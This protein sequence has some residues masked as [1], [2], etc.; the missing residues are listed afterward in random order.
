MSTKI[1][2]VLLHGGR[3][4]EHA[5]SC[6]TAKE[7]LK[8]IDRERFDVIP[9]GITQTGHM[10]LVAEEDMN[11]ALIAGALPEVVDNGSRFHWPESA[12]S[13]EISVT[14]ADG[15]LQALGTVDLAFPL[16]HGPFGEDGTLQ[17]ML[18]LLSIPFVGNGVLSSALCM[19]KHFTKAV[20]AAA[21]LRVAPG[22]TLTRAQLQ[23]DPTLIARL[24]TDLSYP[25]YIKPARSGS[26]IGVSRVA[27]ASTLPDALAEAF[28]FDDVVL[29][30]SG[31][32]G[33]E[34]EI[35]VL[36]GRSGGSPRTS[37]V[38]G[39]IICSGRDF[40]DFDAKYLGAEGVTLEL[41]AKVS[42]SQLECLQ[43]TAIRAFEATGCAGLAR[44]DF[45]LTEDGAIV[46]EVNTMPGFT[47]ISMYPKL[48]EASG[49][50]YTELVTELIELAL[51]PLSRAR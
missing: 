13:R 18:Q 50:S 39:E 22:R 46:N 29:I 26:S 36:G 34:V 17:G 37:S 32:K 2:V 33:R 30:E 6:V 9:V 28:K 23:R 43:E 19:D 15:Q 41:P 14:T 35:A 11:Y 7:V 49:L 20:L 40:Y 45:F 27:D 8:A 12:Q 51:D 21:G 25:L 47:P 31:V 10:V 38:V 4:S 1:R 44:V 5:I 3:S 48:W 42:N 16:L 24:D